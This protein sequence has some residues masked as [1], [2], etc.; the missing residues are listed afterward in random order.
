MNIIIVLST[1]VPV[2]SYPSGSWFQRSHSNE[3]EVREHLHVNVV[4][5]LVCAICMNH[6]GNNN[7]ME[8]PVISV[9]E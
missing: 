3:C 5:K 1:A 6:H 2:R 8:A 7:I 4:Q 9:V